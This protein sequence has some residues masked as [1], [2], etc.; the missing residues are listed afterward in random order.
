MNFTRERPVFGPLPRIFLLAG[1]VALGACRAERDS[2][3]DISFP[4]S[5]GYTV[6]ATLIMPADLKPPGIILLHM[7]GSDR[8]AWRGFQSQARADGYASIAIDLRGHGQTKTT[9]AGG[10]AAR[11]F[12][13][14]DWLDV[15][16]DI[17]GA[18][19]A[20][21]EAGADPAK[22]ALMGASIGANLAFRYTATDPEVHAV[23]MLSPG[24]DYSGVTTT[25]TMETFT[26]RPVLLMAARGDSYAAASAQKLDALAKQFCELRLYPGAAHGT[27]LLGA[28]PLAAEQ[29][30]MWL[31]QVLNHK[32]ENI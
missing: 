15:L 18:K 25:K 28:E 12:S 6:A 30:L 7:V 24:E 20:L 22:I 5:G 26:S 14:N 13:A 16:D 1:V 11:I 32:A 21:V 29:V 31:D 10:S 3:K 9:A 23:V 27:D 17:A 19:R 8:G 2:G 4:S